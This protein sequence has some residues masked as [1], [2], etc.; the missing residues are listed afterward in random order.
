MHVGLMRC[1]LRLKHQKPIAQH[2]DAAEVAVAAAAA[3]AAVQRQKLDILERLLWATD[4]GDGAAGAAPAAATCAGTAS[5]RFT[6]NDWT[7]FYRHCL[8]PACI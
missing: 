7:V 4:F 1:I 5:C 8:L 3:E 6:P 2:M